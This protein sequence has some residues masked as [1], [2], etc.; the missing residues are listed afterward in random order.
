M[1]LDTAGITNLDEYYNDNEETA[2]FTSAESTYTSKE[3]DA[4]KQP[5]NTMMITTRL[6]FDLAPGQT[7]PPMWQWVLALRSE[8]LGKFRNE[9]LAPSSAAGVFQRP[10]SLAWKVIED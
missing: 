4:N 5:P 9:Y 2:T 10:T 1:S 6:N 7:S 3:F 8:G